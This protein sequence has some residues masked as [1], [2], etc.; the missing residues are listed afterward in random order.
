MKIST[1]LEREPF[2]K[3]FEKTMASFFSDFT[4]HPHKVKWYPKNH[5]NQNT[6]S[7]QQWYCNPLINSIFVKDANSD[8]FNSISGEYS[9]NPLKPWRSSIQKLYL[10]LSQHQMTSPLMSKYVI[11]VSPPIKDAKN[12]LIVGG[13]TKIRLIDIAN[14]KVYVILK[15]GFDKKYLEKEIYVRTNFIFLPIPKIYTYGSNDLWY[16]EEYVSGKS[17]N[18]SNP[19][20]FFLPRL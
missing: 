15:N 7:I 17:P 9:H 1:L 14:R 3:I 8:V 4:N 5:N 10:S 2:D 16:C 6:A 18:V 12:K 13:N 20:S 19:I 11:E